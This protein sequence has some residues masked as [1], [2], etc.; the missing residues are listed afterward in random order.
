MSTDNAYVQ[1]DMVGLSTDVSGIVTQV[2]VHDNQ[3]VAEG[4]HPV[5]ARRLQFRLALDRADAQLGKTRNELLALQASYRNMQAQ[6]EQAQKDVDFNTVNFKRQ[7]QLVA[8]NFTPQ[9]TFDAARNT[10]QGVAA[11]ARLA[12]TSSSPASPRT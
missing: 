3:K 5:Q 12:A 1:A 11:K 2:V 10:L 6:I 8:N 9:A 7:Q 4:R